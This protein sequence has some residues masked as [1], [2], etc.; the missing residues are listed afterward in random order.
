M[1]EREATRLLDSIMHWVVFNRQMLQKEEKRGV[2]QFWIGYHTG[3]IKMCE[4]MAQEITESI[5]EDEQ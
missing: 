5:E 4:A 1:S 2:D 3:A